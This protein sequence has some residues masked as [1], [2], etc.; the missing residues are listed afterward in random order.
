[1]VRRGSEKRMGQKSPHL[2]DL[3]TWGG[4]GIE[5]RSSD[6]YVKFAMGMSARYRIDWFTVGL[7]GEFSFV[8]VPATQEFLCALVGTTWDFSRRFRIDTLAVAGLHFEQPVGPIGW[9]SEYHVIGREELFVIPYIG[10]R[11]TPTFVFGARNKPH[12]HLRILLEVKRDIGDRES[13]YL[14]EECSDDWLFGG[15]ETCSTSQESYRTGG[16]HFV[17]GVSHGIAFDLGG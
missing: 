4:G 13:R 17:L 15:G 2:I 11:V 9:F 12:Y 8:L 10:A 14:L 3:S 5:L 16:W 1:M 6:E 7:G